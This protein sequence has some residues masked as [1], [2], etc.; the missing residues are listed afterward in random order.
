MKE[1]NIKFNL[2]LN[3]YYFLLKTFVFLQM[4]K[5]G[6]F[7]CDENA[8]FLKGEECISFCTSEEIKNKTCEIKYEKLKTQWIS[9]IIYFSDKNWEYIN[10]MIS[11]NNDL[12][13]LLSAFPASNE[14]LL[15]GITSEGRGYFNESEFH[16]MEIN[17]PN[18]TGRFESEAFMV[19]LLGT[20]NNKEYILSFGKAVQFMEIYD[21]QNE[22][23]YFKQIIYAF[24]RLYDVHQ[25]SG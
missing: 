17:D 25:I 19:K 22:I 18:S 23:I 9:N 2:P 14:R 7:S 21:I 10:P 15:Y 6:K 20:T 8:P 1:N 4:I 16:K 24:H 5:F 11:Q 13:I 3:I 12:I